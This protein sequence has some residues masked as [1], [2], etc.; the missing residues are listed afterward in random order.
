MYIR[1]YVMCM[2]LFKSSIYYD[3]ATKAYALRNGDVRLFVS[4]LVCLFVCLSV[5]RL[6]R[7]L[8]ET[9]LQQIQV[10]H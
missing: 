3:H 5:C 8:A 10:N 6:K 7:V 9:Q 2:K 1:L 4:L